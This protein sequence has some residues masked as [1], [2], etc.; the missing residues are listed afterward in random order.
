M[1]VIFDLIIFVMNSSTS[2]DTITKT[3]MNK[4]NLKDKLDQILYFILD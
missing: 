3:A 4:I 2:F 1:L